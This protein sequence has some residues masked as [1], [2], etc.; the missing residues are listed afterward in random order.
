MWQ[1]LLLVRIR[2]VCV[3]GMTHGWRYLIPQPKRCR[4]SWNASLFN[5]KSVNKWLSWL[6]QPDKAFFFPFINLIHKARTHVFCFL[7]FRI[8]WF[9]VR[10]GFI[11]FSYISIILICSNYH[12]A[13]ITCSAWSLTLILKVCWE[14]Q[15]K[16]RF[17]YRHLMDMLC[18]CTGATTEMQ[19]NL[20]LTVMPQQVR[21]YFGGLKENCWSAGSSEAISKQQVRIRKAN[22]LSAVENSSLISCP[23]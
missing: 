9:G 13:V 20:F 11:A 6:K 10:R 22:L 16:Y 12:K 8:T 4:L 15:E 17:I 5:D 14:E 21:G 23:W 7:L 1:I 19:R 18:N 2:N 3:S